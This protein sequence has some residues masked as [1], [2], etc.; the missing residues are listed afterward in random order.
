MKKIVLALAI[1]ALSTVAFAGD[2]PYVYAYISF[3]PAGSEDAVQVATADLPAPYTTVSAYVCLGNVEGGMTTLSFL[4]KDPM[5][6]CPGVMAT[7]AFV[8]L[9]P[10]NLAIG[11]AFVGGLTVAST[12]CMPGPIV[13][14]GRID[15][16]YLGGECCFEIL[17]HLDYPRWVV[18]CN[19]PGLVDYYCLKYHGILGDGP[20]CTTLTEYPC[21]GSP[22]EDTTWG[23]IKALYQ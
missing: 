18:D 9:L 20:V 21:E 2:N 3:D 14:I 16:F 13:V 8:N 19:E 6:Y 5:V 17:D 15:C 12:E 10:G 11:D 23:G 22:V 4:L 1:L 7:K